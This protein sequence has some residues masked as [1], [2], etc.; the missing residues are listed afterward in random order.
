MRGYYKLHALRC[1]YKQIGN[2]CQRVGMQTEFRF[3]D[4]YER[5]R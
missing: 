2:Q 5:W 3:F 4:A 1:L